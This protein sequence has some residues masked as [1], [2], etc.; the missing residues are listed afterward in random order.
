MKTILSYNSFITLLGRVGLVVMLLAVL[1]VCQNTTVTRAQP[2]TVELV[3]NSAQGRPIQAYRFGHGNTHLAFIGGIHQGNEANSTTLIEQAVTYYTDHANEIPQDLTVFLIPNVNPDGFAIKQ[4]FN[5]RGV[6]LNRNWPTT[7]WKADTYDV[8][9]LIKGGGGK[10]PLSEPETAGLWQYIQ[11]NNIISTIFYHARGADV[12]DTM[13]TARGHRYATTVAK[14]LAW[15]TGYNYLET[16]SYYD[17]SGDATDFLNSKGIYALTVELSG[18]ND[19]DW[20]QNLRGF[21]AVISFFTPRVVNQTGH[22]ISGRV[23]AFWNSNGGEKIFGNPIS[24]PKVT[25]DKTW[26]AFEHGSITL[27][28]A[29]GLLVWG[30]GADGP[31]DFPVNGSDGISE[32]VQ[33]QPAVAAP[34]GPLL[35]YPGGIPAPTSSKIQAVNVKSANLRQKID[36]LQMQAS[37]LE[38]QFYN[39][40]SRIIGSNTAATVIN[41]LPAP[42]VGS[43]N[44]P[45]PNLND[46][47]I[48]LAL[49]LPNMPGKVIKVVLGPN[50]T[51]TVYAYENA[52]LVRTI[53]AFSGKP[54][55]ETPRGQFKIH[56][57]N[58]SLTTNKWY[59]NDG[60]E[61]MLNNY[62][63]FT[64]STLDNSD[65]WAFHQM[66]I[67]ISGQDKG[68][69]QAGPSHG[70]LALSPADAQWVFDWAVEGTA[71]YIT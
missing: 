32:P 9:G 26:Q 59:E 13:P 18:Y 50:S 30:P 51:A 39:L 52:K 20:A 24:D 1:L 42:L 38:K 34:S 71:V 43:T 6:D 19:P 70:C 3:G 25:T 35:P 2:Y 44:Q 48:N 22:T 67:P 41:N 37:D 40:S 7:D 46:P 68:Q 56:Y 57:K 21:S 23:L 17:L 16:W 12:V 45:F 61:Y 62:S 31:V 27:D 8:D 15:A 53:G 11:S 29:T 10:A 14:N 63:S 36:G 66:R 47:G 58:P 33:I 28:N 65:D 5:A 49:P 54:G 55:Y 69:M 60:T 4:R 64:G